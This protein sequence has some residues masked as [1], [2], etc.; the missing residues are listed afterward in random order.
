MPG[1]ASSVTHNPAAQRFEIDIG[2][3]LATCHYRRS[4][5]LLVLH[6]TEVP[7]AAQGQG[8]AATLVAAA[9]AW[10]RAEGL[11]V[12]PTCSYVA[13]YM[14]HH[15]ET[16]DLLEAPVATARDVLAFWFGEPAATEPRPEWFRKD[17]AFDT[18]I[19]QRFGSTLDAAL[20]GGLRQWDATPPGALARVVVLDQF[21]RN[22][23]R[24]T[25]RAFA[26]DAL[27]LA[28]A[29]SLVATGGDRDLLPQ[30]RW[31]A[32]LPFEH[33]EDLGLQQRAVQLFAALAEEHPALA[34]AVVW[35][36]KHLDVVAR[37]GRFP[38]RNAIVG[39]VSTAEEEAFLAQP[40]S[41]F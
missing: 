23:F 16:L 11:Q 10:A 14:R 31:F 3:A 9:L 27:A 33:A 6:H 36:Q 20:A 13:S 17:A 24:D 4:G 5:G 30:Q 12:R 40:G 2:G 1:M 8:L 18:L 32:Y 35:A 29:E 41:R 34:D 15:P 19:R 21:T 39:R 37:F 22:S 28:A 38:H 26:G 25:P 7:P